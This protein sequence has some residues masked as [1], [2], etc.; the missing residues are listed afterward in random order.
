MI[1][2]KHSVSKSSK[3]KY[4]KQ[5]DS[6]EWMHVLGCV[7]F[8]IPFL[9]SIQDISN[10]TIILRFTFLILLHKIQNNEIKLKIRQA[11]ET[12][13]FYT[14]NFD[15]Y[16]SAKLY[17]PFRYQI[18]ISVHVSYAPSCVVFPLLNHSLISHCPQTI[19]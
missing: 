19:F 11:F 5:C 6:C 14:N 18:I 4:T 1:K 7:Q 12:S 13:K 15:S 16:F 17:L 9:E 10:D 3:S 2:Q 8:P